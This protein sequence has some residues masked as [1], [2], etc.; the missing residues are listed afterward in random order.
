MK[1]LDGW[2]TVLGVAGCVL[3]VALPRAQ[4]GVIGG[5]LDNAN[6]AVVGVFGLLTVLGIVHKVE[7]R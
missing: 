3:T 6:N 5:I 4:P 2:K 7:K 1:F